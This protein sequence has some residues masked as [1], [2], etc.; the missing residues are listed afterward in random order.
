MNK[1]QNEGAMKQSR[2]HIVMTGATSGFGVHIVEHL[3]KSPCDVIIFARSKSKYDTLKQRCSSVAHPEARLHFI[4]CNLSSLQSVVHAC[5][6]VK[7][8]FKHIDILIQNAGIMNFDFHETEDGIEETLQVNLIAP[9]LITNQLTP[10][11]PT[12]GSAKILYTASALHQGTIQF[13]DLEFRN[14]FSSFRSYRNSKLGIILM[15]R[16][17]AKQEAYKHITVAAVHPGMIRTQLG[18]S[19]GWLSR[20]I[21]KILGKPVE[22]GTKTH[23]SLLSKDPQELTSGEYYANSKVQK[24]T[25]ESYDLNMAKQLERRIQAYLKPY[26]IG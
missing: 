21:F 4:S 23:I 7:R 13:D 10:R 19:A 26:V 18:R 25:P 16:L 14:K 17:Q 5:E 20:M 22:E 8:Q 24:I 12:D 2:Q 11:I 1:D 9:M 3:L 6:E 15:T